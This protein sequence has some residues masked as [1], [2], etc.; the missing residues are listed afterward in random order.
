M[1]TEHDLQLIYFYFYFKLF[2]ENLKELKMYFLSL[3]LMRNHNKIINNC[4]ILAVFYLKS[5]L[6]QVFV[7]LL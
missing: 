6:K 4:I 3:H 2:L 1:Y 5:E 7:M